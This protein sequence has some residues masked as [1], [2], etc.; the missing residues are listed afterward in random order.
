M[1]E[2]R[3][4]HKYDVQ[5]WLGLGFNLCAYATSQHSLSYPGSQTSKELLSRKVNLRAPPEE[6]KNMPT[7]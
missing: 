7:H 5:E 6:C 3:N 1:Q 2:L 4:K